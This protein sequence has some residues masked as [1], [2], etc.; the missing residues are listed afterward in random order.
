MVQILYIAFTIVVAVLAAWIIFLQTDKKTK[1]LISVVLIWALCT[2]GRD[3]YDF[4]SSRPKPILVLDQIEEL[5]D[6]KPPSAVLFF[7]KLKNN[8]NVTATNIHTHPIIGIN[9]E[10]I[11]DKITEQADISPGVTVRLRFRLKG[12]T[13]EKV[14]NESSELNLDLVISYSDPPGNNYSGN[15]AAKYKPYPDEPI[16]HPG[17]TIIK[18]KQKN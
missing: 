18:N 1:L 8:G 17:W 10:I 7:I 2:A 16:I 15:Y 3:V 4:V 6:K 5:Y 9:D 12:E 14:W 13:F 11:Y